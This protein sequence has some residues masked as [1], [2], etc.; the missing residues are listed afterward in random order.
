[1]KPIVSF[2]IFLTFLFLHSFSEAQTSNP[3]I[4]NYYN[5]PQVIYENP[6]TT[7]PI[8]NPS[9]TL[10]GAPSTPTF[11]LPGQPTTSQ[12]VQPGNATT[13]SSP[14]L[15]QQLYPQPAM[16][17][18]QYQPLNPPPSLMYQPVPF[19]TIAPPSSYL[20][21]IATIKDK[22]WMVSDYLYNLTPNIGI[23]VE[24]IKPEKKYIPLSSDILER[25]IT[26]VFENAR[27]NPN[28]IL[29]NCQPP[30]P[31]FYVLVMV[32][33]CEKRCVAFITAQLYEIAKPARIDIDLNGVWQAITWERQTLVASAWEDF[34]QEVASALED[35]ALAFTNRFNFYHPIL[36]R[37]CYPEPPYTKQ[38]E[39]Y[40]RYYEQ[41]NEC[42]AH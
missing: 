14:S 20:P 41:H 7:P 17:N 34:A 3:S 29:A 19:E 15:L 23:K 2:P 21:G 18:A 24:V 31:M 36:E 25:K 6:L 42:C 26:G 4:N 30:L 8:F 35:I 16:P 37:P 39:L 10:P 33:P 11:G 12:F 38:K 28:P 27:I 32:Y 22:K 5:T 13:P 9:T 1:M 40:Q